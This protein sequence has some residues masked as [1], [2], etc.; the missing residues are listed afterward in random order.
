[1][2]YFF[3]KNWVII[4]N[5]FA[6]NL[7]IVYYNKR[8]NSASNEA[9]IIEQTISIYIAID[10]INR[11]SKNII[12]IKCNKQ[13]RNIIKLV[14]KFIHKVRLNA[15]SMVENDAHITLIL[16]WGRRS[17]GFDYRHKYMYSIF[18]KI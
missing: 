16:I 1:M 5:S 4:L 17:L 14:D 7:W 12:H 11:I 8:I 3:L 13:I 18:N 2:L 9:N 6:I 15:V 10:N